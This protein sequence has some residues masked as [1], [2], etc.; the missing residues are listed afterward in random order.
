M[1][2]TAKSIVVLTSGEEISSPDTMD[3]LRG[4][5]AR[6]T[7]WIEVSDQVGNPHLVQVSRIVEI[8]PTGL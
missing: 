8:H 3:D 1:A 4:Q 2:E 6:G 7:G 5:L